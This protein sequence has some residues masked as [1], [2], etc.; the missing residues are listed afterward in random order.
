MV[1]ISDPLLF[2]NL[3]GLRKVLA[4]GKKQNDKNLEVS[5]ES[6]HAKMPNR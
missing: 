1:N 2:K 4:L 5:A 3:T 6:S